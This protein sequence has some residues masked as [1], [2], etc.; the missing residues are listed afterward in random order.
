MSARAAA[1]AGAS[2]MT[3]PERVAAKAAGGGAVAGGDDEVGAA[4][5]A[6]GQALAH[7]AQ[8][9][10]CCGGHFSVSCGAEVA[11]TAICTRGI[12]A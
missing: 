9:D 4:G 1:S 7:I 3:L 8:A 11:T 10:D 12:V 2:A 6:P 5:Q